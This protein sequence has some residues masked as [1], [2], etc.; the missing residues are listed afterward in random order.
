MPQGSWGP[1]KGWM[2]SGLD[3][4]DG[5]GESWA[6]IISWA[7]ANTGKIEKSAEKISAARNRN[8]GCRVRTMAIDSWAR[9]GLFL[10]VIRELPGSKH[11]LP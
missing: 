1:N 8:M 10:F 7:G 9:G 2:A 11:R 3:D 6:R 4:C 5:V